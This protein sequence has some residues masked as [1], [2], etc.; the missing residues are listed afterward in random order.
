[1]AMITL[2]LPVGP[3]A[4]E[5]R[6]H[7]EV[8][9]SEEYN[10]NIFLTRRD[11]EFDYIT[12]VI[13]SIGI[14]YKAPLWDWDA[15]YAYDY[16]YYARAAFRHD[17]TYTVS[18]TNLTRLAKDLLF[19]AVRD[20]YSRVS[21]DLARDFTQ[22]SLFVNQSDQNILSANP[23]ITLHPG[24]RTSVNVGYIYQNIWYKDPIAIDKIDHITYAEMAHDLS[25]QLKMTITGRYTQDTN[26]IQDY[27][28]SDLIA[29]MRYEYLDGSFLFGSIGNTW[30]RV[31]SGES[32]TQIFWNAGF[33]HSFPKFKFF[34]ETALSYPNDPK[35]V[36]RRED[37]YA[38]TIKREVERTS[39]GAT[40][41][42]TEYRNAQTKHL[43]SSTYSVSGTISHS[44]TEQSKILAELTIQRLEDNVN[45]T[46]SDLYLSGVRYEY[47]GWENGT[48]AFT[49]R[50]TNSYSPDV[51]DPAL[52]NTSNYQNNRIMIEFT[53][54]F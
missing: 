40:A 35:N 12:R 10:D 25:S 19:L 48:L 13:P 46:Y 44:I 15:S 45:D 26:R 37:R 21:L 31:A 4:A 20:T 7:T 22:Q 42:L 1:M 29:G 24:A 28:Q 27:N 43:E 8:T 9:A 5:Y 53:N 18:L 3:A 23:Y 51:Y 47:H 41:S 32:S 39:L 50:Y 6:L 2:L 14:T 36:L 38:A 30:V 34:F 11:S 33:T 16:R 52:Y 49:Y 54:K 17:E